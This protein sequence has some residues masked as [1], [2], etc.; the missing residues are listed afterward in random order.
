MTQSLL[1]LLLPHQQRLRA[2]I[3]EVLDLE[4]IS[5]QADHGT[6]DFRRYAAFVVDKMATFCAPVRDQLIASLRDVDDVI[7]LYRWLSWWLPICFSVSVS[8]CLS[9]SLSLSLS[10]SLFERPFSR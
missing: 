5:Q 8:V 6:L 7:T 4:L 2:S 10:L 1:E 3:E 9:V